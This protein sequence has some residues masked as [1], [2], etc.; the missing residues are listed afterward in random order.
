MKST[1]MIESNISE[2]IY[3]TRSKVLMFDDRFYS[4]TRMHFK[5]MLEHADCRWPLKIKRGLGFF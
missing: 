1:I 4:I 3:K 5:S 2:A